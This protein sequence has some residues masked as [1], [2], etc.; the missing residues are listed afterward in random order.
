[1][2]TG[3][4][5]DVI[6]PIRSRNIDLKYIKDIS[7]NRSFSLIYSTGNGAT[8]SQGYISA[9]G[10]RPD[11]KT[12]TKGTLTANTWSAGIFLVYPGAGRA[13]YVKRII[14]DSTDD[15]IFVVRQGLSTIEGITRNLTASFNHYVREQTNASGGQV[16]FDF[17]NDPV[18]VPYGEFMELFYSRN[19]AGAPNIQVLV[20]YDDV[21]NTS[22]YDADFL[23][24]L[25]GDSFLNTTEVDAIEYY[26]NNGIITGTWPFITYNYLKEN[27]INC[28]VS[29]LGLGG[30]GT[31]HWSVKAKLGL[32]RNWKPD[33]LHINSGINDSATLANATNALYKVYVK[34][35]INS[36]FLERP[37]GCLIWNQITD[38][39]IAAN[40]ANVITG[41][42]T[43]MTSIQA[44][45]LQLTEVFA[46][47]KA[48]HPTWDMVIADTSPAN[49]FLATDSSN[50]IETSAGTRIHPNAAVG[51]PKMAI[52]IK[53]A[54]ENTLFF[55]KYRIA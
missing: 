23:Y 43:G 4:P 22:N 32:F 11:W 39:D 44:I 49:T 52:K 51:Q 9:G 27:G 34:N 47:L 20:E 35:I 21:S 38:T 7:T 29:N 45:R 12:V 30:S 31:Q 10:A 26:N 14:I 40:N 28:L 37:D 17:T 46:E 6:N 18:K 8:A 53:E 19:T 3:F 48:L 33:I 15:A 1:M 50:Y 2:I 55:N 16:V 25:I 13:R 41:P 5:T 36:Y 42:Y 24:G 54:L